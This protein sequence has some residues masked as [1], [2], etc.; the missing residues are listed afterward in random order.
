MRKLVFTGLAM[1]MATALALVEPLRAEEQTAGAMKPVV[2]VKVAGYQTALDNAARIGA[3]MNNPD[4]GKGIDA[5]LK[6]FTQGRGIQGLDKDRAGGAVIETDGEKVRGYA[7]VPVT[8]LKE[9]LVT[10]EPFAGKP[11]EDNG[12]YRFDTPQG[13]VYVTQKGAWAYLAKRAEVLATV[14][15][16]PQEILDA[17]DGGYESAVRVLLNNVPAAKRSEAIARLQEAAQRSIEHREEGESD[18]IYAARK[19][20]VK[21][22]S[23][24]GTAI[25]QD[26]ECVTIGTK[27]EDS[28]EVTVEL[29]AIA[30]PGSDVAIEL[31]KSKMVESTFAGT[32]QPGAAISST[33]GV[34]LPNVA[35]E[36][37]LT[38]LFDLLKTEAFRNIDRTGKKPE[39]IS[40]G[41][42]F[43][44]GVLRVVRDTL[45]T[46]RLDGAMS[47]VLEP[48][49]ATLLVGR[50]VSSGDELEEA[51]G[52]MV[53]A[54]R[55]E[56]PEFVDQVL[57]TN[58]AEVNGIR[59]HRVAFPIDANA[60]DREKQER[61]FGETLDLV[62]GIGEKTVYLAAGRDALDVLKEAVTKTEPQ[63]IAPM[64]V[65]VSLRELCEFGAAMAPP[66]EQRRA[67]RAAKMMQESEEE[68][69]VTLR[70]LPVENGIRWRLSIDPGVVQLI[71]RGGELR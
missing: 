12:V 52:R 44:G 61:L 13:S 55:S 45:L 17:L 66:E 26:T 2:L 21:R 48:D 57:Q 39:T 53:D 18:E 11:A 27:M 49:R 56:K 65:K 30:R 24:I 9:V 50:N 46:G 64:T 6:L 62:V 70:C 63:E 47:L 51:L 4:L 41:K 20:V 23:E 59:M 58:V 16:N 8:D 19:G 31:N 35:S 29:T 38:D 10:L 32:V 71:F 14:A 37:E 15:E 22:L 67:E 43:V 7:F 68:D 28:G 60:P 36:S 5:M 40:A 1:A 42:D 33:W 54:V 3:M 34:A 25:L 69:C